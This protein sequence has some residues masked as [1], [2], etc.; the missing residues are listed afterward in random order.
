MLKLVSRTLLSAALLA[1][2]SGS[3]EPM[4]TQPAKVKGQYN[5]KADGFTPNEDPNRLLSD[6]TFRFIDV[7][8]TGDVGA[9]YGTPNDSIPYPDTYWAMVNEGIDWNWTG[10]SSPLEKY[11]GLTDPDHTSDAKGWEHT[12]H[13]AGVPGV[14]DWFGHCPGWTAAAMLNSPIKHAVDARRDDQGNLVACDAGSAGCV[15]FEIG[16][17]NALEAEVYVD[18]DSKFIGARCDTKPSDIPRDEFGRIARNGTGCK[19]LNAGALMVVMANVMGFGGR[20]FAIDAQNRFNTDQIWNQPAYRYTVNRFETL[21]EAQAA[22]LVAH[23]TKTGDQTKYRWNPAS[24]GWAFVDV[25]LQWITEHGP[26]VEPFSG[27]DSTKVTRMVA[28]I[29]LDD[30]SSNGD[31]KVIGGEYLDDPSVGADRLTVPPF[32]W[33]A[34]DAGPENLPEWV[35]GNSHNPYVKPSLV[36]QLIALGQS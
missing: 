4:T 19:G 3:D 9:L 34:T 20:A 13:G 33:M 31:A 8:N 7:V 29:E 15:H 30:V 1:G 27:A 36:K 17:I 25:S 10:S 14:A 28:V 26:N 16:D 22:N 12:N 32:V 24:K 21:T 18:A 11:M 2:C 6:A 5:G 23:G 35:N